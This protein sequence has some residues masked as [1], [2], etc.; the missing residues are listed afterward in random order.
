MMAM[1]YPGLWLGKTPNSIDCIEY[2]F[3]FSIDVP[4]TAG[5]R[6][7]R[8]GGP[9]SGVSLR[10]GRPPWAVKADVAPL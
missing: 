3:E 9:T 8:M 10:I 7:W 5:W 6:C 2:E 4:S 1:C